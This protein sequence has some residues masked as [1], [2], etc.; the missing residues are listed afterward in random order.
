V[1][2]GFC[3]A[4]IGGA[5]SIGHSSIDD[6]G[7]LMVYQAAIDGAFAVDLHVLIHV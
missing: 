3:Q 7:V 1:R 5:I 2:V 6:A 4:T